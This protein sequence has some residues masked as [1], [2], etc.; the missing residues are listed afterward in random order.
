MM[1]ESVMLKKDDAR[2]RDART[3]TTQTSMNSAGKP[4]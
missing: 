3:S 4:N 1:I 2:K